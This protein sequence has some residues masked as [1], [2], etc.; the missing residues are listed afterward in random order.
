TKGDDF[1]GAVTSVGTALI[2]FANDVRPIK[3]RLQTLKADAESF[4]SKI[5]GDEDW[6]EDEDKINE[7]DSLNNDILQAVFEYQRAERECANTI[8]AL[9]GGTTFVATEPGEQG[10]LGA[11]QVAHGTSEALKDIETPWVTPQEHDAP[12]WEDVGNGI[13]DF[14]VGIAEDLGALVGL[15]GEGGWGV[16][17]WSEWGSNLKN[18]WGD[19]LNGLGSLVGFYGKDGWGVSSF[20]EWWGNFSSGWTEFAHA[21]V[22]W[23][24]WGDRPGYVIT[25]SV[26]NIGSMALGGAGVVKALAKGARKVGG[27]GSETSGDTN[28]DT[29]S[30]G[31]P[32]D[33]QLQGLQQ[34][35]N[36]PG[37][38]STQDLQNQLD[39]M[40]LDQDQLQGLQNSLDDA[41]ALE[42]RAT[43]V[44]GGNDPVD[45]DPAFNNGNGGQYQ[46]TGNGGGSPGGSGGPGGGSPDGPGSGGHPSDP[47]GPGGPSGP[48]GPL[49]GLDGN[50]GPDG[51]QNGNQQDAGNTETPADPVDTDPARPGNTPDG[52]APN[53]DL[54]ETTDP[55]DTDPVDTDPADTDP[56]D[57]DTG[58]TDPAD[59]DPVDTDPVDNVDNNA[60][61]GDTTPGA[62]PDSGIDPNDPSTWPGQVDEDG[63]RHF[64][65]DDAGEQYGEEVLRPETYERLTESQRE[66]LE[67]YTR[68]SWLNPILRGQA[69]TQQILDMKWKSVGP[70]MHLMDMVDGRISMTDVERA[71]DNQKDLTEEQRIIVNDI[72]QSEN[73]DARLEQWID[74][75]GGRGRM[76]Q[77]FDGFPTPEEVDQRI[78]DM[79]A[80]FQR[81]A[82]PEDVEVVR[83]LHDFSFM[84]GFDPSSPNAYEALKKMIGETQ[85]D[86]AYMSTSLGKNPTVVDNNPYEYKFHLNVPEGHPGVWMGKSSIYPDQ[87]ELI[88]PRGTEYVIRSVEKLGDGSIKVNADVLMPGKD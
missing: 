76:I 35:G 69:T 33:G 70:G 44:G 84:K 14:G 72:M 2:N 54:G 67:D 13:K 82:L 80:G 56:V 10:S 43:P 61:A 5:S 64:D 65:T 8:T 32:S 47:G 66:G 52:D 75:A 25:Q 50:G 79:D 27:D 77:T 60:P 7:L 57:A 87:R 81:T 17:S 46:S 48:S 83:G 88:L 29:D 45:V 74:S 30:N 42:N 11:N 21:V 31:Q 4:Q 41:E 24:E 86:N 73:P 6:R 58:D 63:V 51:Q 20:G 55:V 16:S 39:D 38:Q 1:D 40:S 22:P 36:R 59:T 3:R 19:T 12:W 28:G 26:L 9:F 23:R 68:Q 85:S 71:F 53:S 62:D 15:Y 49:G 37:Q 18:N 34:I 78:A